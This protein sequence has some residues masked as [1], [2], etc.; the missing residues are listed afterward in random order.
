MKIQNIR[1][2]EYLKNETL[3]RWVSE[4]AALV[5]PE[6]VYFCDGSDEEYGRLCDGMVAS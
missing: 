6:E 1:F 2:P 3:K 4:T 5:E